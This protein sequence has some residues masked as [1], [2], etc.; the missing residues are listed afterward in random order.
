MTQ[1]TS[2]F[3]S[4]FFKFWQHYFSNTP[5]IDFGQINLPINAK[6]CYKSHDRIP[7]TESWICIFGEFIHTF[8]KC[9]TLKST[10]DHNTKS[11][12]VRITL[13]FSRGSYFL[14]FLR[15]LWASCWSTKRRAFY[16]RRV[17]SRC[18]TADKPV[19]SKINDTSFC[20]STTDL[21]IYFC[22]ILSNS[23]IFI[24]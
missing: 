8:N 24:Y 16:F 15:K 22:S 9:I 5:L 21:L 19:S 4:F 12:T 20:W 7:W 23:W 3:P 1:V 18:C 6:F 2:K 13:L 10:F 17:E 11:V 14:P